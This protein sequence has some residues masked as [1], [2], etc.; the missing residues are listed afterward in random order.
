MFVEIEKFY[1]DSLVITFHSQ[2]MSQFIKNMYLDI[3]FHAVP[4]IHRNNNLSPLENYITSITT[5]PVRIIVYSDFSYLI[6]H[7]PQ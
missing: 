3:I 1:Y 2:S 4:C 5:V 7:H 6:H